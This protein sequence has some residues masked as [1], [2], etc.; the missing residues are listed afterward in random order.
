MI[1]CG[2][3][4]WFDLAIRPSQTPEEESILPNSKNYIKCNQHYFC[5]KHILLCFLDEIEI[6]TSDYN[7]LRYN[8]ENI[9]VR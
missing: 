3:V 9:K 6:I 1:P 4:D 5:S 7:L 2:H 8:N